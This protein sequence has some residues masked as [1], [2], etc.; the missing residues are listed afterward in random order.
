MSAYGYR[1]AGNA[2]NMSPGFIPSL[3]GIDPQ[4][5]NPNGMDTY[6]ERVDLP[7]TALAITAVSATRWVSYDSL[8]AGERDPIVAVR[9]GSLAFYST[10]SEII[11]LLEE[12]GDADAKSFIPHIRNIGSL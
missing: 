1:L 2:K 9:A 6:F 8:P 10:R 12:F 4:Q 3:I 11:E 5:V 7:D